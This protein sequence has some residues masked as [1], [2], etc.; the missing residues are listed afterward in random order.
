MDKNQ[1][2]LLIEL[3]NHETL[4]GKDLASRI[5][6]STRSVRTIIKNINENII[7][8]RIE[9]GSFG[10]QLHI[11]DSELFLSYLQGNQDDTSR[12][13][14]LFNRFI[15]N[16]NYLK[17]DDLCD[18][19][20]LSR[21][22]LKQELKKLRQY[23][24]EHGI[25]IETKAH[26]GMRLDG[27]EINIRKAIGHLQDYPIDKS[28]FEQ[29]KKILISSIAN[30]DFVVTDDNL[31]NISHYLYIAYI[32]TSKH[33]FVSI[34]E[35]WMK[36]IKEEKE[37]LLA[38]SMMIL[39]S[40]ILNMEYQEGEVAYLTMHLCG[41]NSQQTSQLY[42]DQEIYNVVNEFLKVIEKSSG[43]LLS[44]DLNL[45][46]S[47]SLHMIPLL[48]RIQ[49]QMYMDNPLLLDIKKRLIV[50]YELAVKGCELIN[51][52]YHCQLPDDEIAYFALHINLSLEQKKNH[53][54]KKNILL[55][56][57]SGV[58]SARLL[59]Y[60]FKEHFR[61]YID[62]LDVCSL[63]E[64]E[65]HNMEPYDCIFTTVPLS[66]Q[67]SIPIFMIHSLMGYED[68]LKIS[69]QLKQ[70]NQIPIMQYFPKQL[71]FADQQFSSKEEA[72]HQIIKQCHQYYQ[73]PDSFE[74]LVL[75]R[76]QLA[77]TEFNDFVAFP[78]SHRPVT[79]QTFVSVTILKK[80]LLWK[81]HHIRI[82]LLSSIE[83][84]MIKE[85]DH[86]YQAISTFLSQQTLQWELIQNPTYEQ[87]QEIMKKVQKQ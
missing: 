21:T 61:D 84:K 32:R 29:I 54:Y 82:I 71:F 37:W 13:L 76:E 23:F 46:A 58:G 17:I 7:G 49:Y 80:P 5:Q 70:L 8:A 78:H 10:Y 59:E 30:Y 64:L 87:L 9:S 34:D 15:D 41:K 40:H 53:I 66:R 27:N 62:I 44:T 75:E 42:I 77:T 45:Q 39:M 33:H 2:N 47:L 22:Q 14:Y 6:M 79:S 67:I 1:K 81:N 4:S 28:I 11:E 60:F 3:M 25:M 35:A 16:Q 38:S 48:K 56:C 68:T 85:L 24:V 51:K 31:E 26:Y 20:Y 50:A 19:L 69:H 36:E 65:N 43:I 18:E 73:L 74:S 52:H 57:S 63:L 55:V 72:I 83:N 86:F 12:F